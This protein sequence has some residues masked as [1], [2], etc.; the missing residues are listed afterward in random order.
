M[1]IFK[2]I[3][4]TVACIWIAP[5]VSVM[6]LGLI[7]Y[8]CYEEIRY[9]NTGMLTAIFEGISEGIDN[10]ADMVKEFMAD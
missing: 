8:A 6:Y 1:K 10:F 2:L 9:K 5:L 7:V 3:W 4:I